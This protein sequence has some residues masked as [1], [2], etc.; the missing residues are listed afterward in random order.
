MLKSGYTLLKHDAAQSL[1][2]FRNTPDLRFDLQP[3]D[4][5]FSDILTFT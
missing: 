3:E 1:Y 4:F 2:I 5:V